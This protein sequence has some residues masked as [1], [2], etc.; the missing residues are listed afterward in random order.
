MLG[1]VQREPCWRPQS[2]SAAARSGQTRLRMLPPTTSTTTGRPDRDAS[3][4]VTGGRRTRARPTGAGL[5]AVPHGDVGRGNGEFEAVPAV[6]EG[7]RKRVG[8]DLAAGLCLEAGDG[9]G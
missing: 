1:V 6:R 9:G 3:A 5:Q 7:Y 4:A 2:C 8:D